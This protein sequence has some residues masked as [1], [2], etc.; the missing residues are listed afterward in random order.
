MSYKTPS[1]PTLTLKGLDDRIQSVQD[2][3]SDLTWLTKSFGMADRIVSMLNEKPY[4]YPATFETNVIDPINLMPGDAWTAY[5]FWVKSGDSKIESNSNPRNPLIKVPVSCIFYMDI[6]R[7]DGTT[8]YKETKSKIIE[9]I[10]NFFNK[11]QVSGRLQILKFVEDDIT[12]V[13][14]G[15][16]LD[17]L[18]NKFRMYP[19]WCCRVDFELSY[20]NN[21]CTSTFLAAP[22]A[23]AA[24]N[25]LGDRFT[26]NWQSVTGATGYELQASSY[27]DFHEYSSGQTTSLSD[28]VYA[29]QNT[30]YYYRVRAYTSTAQS[31]WS[32]VITLK[33]LQTIFDDWYLPSKNEL[34]ALYTVLEFH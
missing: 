23:T 26:A 27:S 25:I 11:V 22:V 8:S 32:N 30:T 31:A 6:R 19:K 17:Q 9:D 20:R 33:T 24:T 2:L 34:N 14:D 18:D 10:F 5:S 29:T 1:I 13:F 12:K 28:L 7:I 3:M 21:F 4:I 16:T 15:F